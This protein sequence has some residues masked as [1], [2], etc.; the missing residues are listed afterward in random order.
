M[1]SQ[2]AA[3]VSRLVTI[4]GSIISLAL[5]TTGCAWLKSS[6][7]RWEVTKQAESGKPLQPVAESEMVFTLLEQIYTDKLLTPDANLLLIEETLPVTKKKSMT[8]PQDQAAIG[9]YLKDV[10]KMC[11]TNFLKS[12][13][14]R[15]KIDASGVPG[16]KLQVANISRIN[17]L[18]NGGGWANVQKT[19]PHA[20]AMISVSRAGTCADHNESLFYLMS[21]K[22]DGSGEGI[23]VHGKISSGTWSV[24]QKA[25]ISQADGL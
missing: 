7:D 9:G 24:I 16:G 2:R 20:Q 22:A 11:V 6:E 1:P 21:T 23:L 19:F 13:K 18:F 25:V 10:N 14:T 12:N 17:Q 4:L 3:R 5:S 8:F 15:Y